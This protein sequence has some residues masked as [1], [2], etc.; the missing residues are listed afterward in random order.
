[1][2]ESTF[3][4]MLNKKQKNLI[5]ECV[6]K[7]PKH[8]VK[9]FTNN[10]MMPLLDKLSNENKD[11]MIMHDFNVNLINC[12]DGKNTSNFLDAMLSQSF[13]PFITTSIRITRNTKTLLTIFFK[14]N[15]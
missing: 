5:T 4:K 13:L 3:I 6:Y 11:I 15:L 14:T 8:E 12:N 10:H 1:M 7:H 2:I 9:D